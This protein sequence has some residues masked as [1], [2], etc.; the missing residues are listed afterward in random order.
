MEKPKGVSLAEARK[1]VIRVLTERMKRAG[2]RKPIVT[3]RGQDGIMVQLPAVTDR[4]RYR[5]LIESQALMR[6]MLVAEDRMK[7][8]QFSES[9]LVGTFQRAVDELNAEFAGKKGAF[10]N[11]VEWRMSDLDQKVADFIPPDTVLRIYQHEERGPSGTVT[12]RTPL[13]LRSSP[14]EPEVIKGSQI[15]EAEFARDP[16]TGQPIV[17]FEFNREGRRRFSQVTREYSARSE[18]RITVPGQDVRGWRLAVLLDDSVISAPH[19]KT[20][21]LGGSG[22]IEGNFTPEEARDLAIQLKAGALPGQ[23]LGSLLRVAPRRSRAADSR[24]KAM[25]D[26]PAGIGASSLGACAF[27]GVRLARSGGRTRG[28]RPRRPRPRLPGDASQ[29]FPPAPTSAERCGSSCYLR[30]RGLP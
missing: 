30:P 6:W 14:E 26:E 17:I 19:I 16:E 20:K 7:L 8:D 29:I 22:Q 12:R 4:T 3:P 2:V 5:R 10:G 28:L 11:P 15:K 25:F 18:N 9:R 27:R 23:G 24:G 1:G 21:I 13:L